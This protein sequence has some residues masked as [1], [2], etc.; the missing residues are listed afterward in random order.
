[1]ATINYWHDKP[2]QDYVMRYLISTLIIAA[3]SISSPSAMDAKDELYYLDDEGS[4]TVGL[5]H[6]RMFA[7]NTIFE[8][9]NSQSKM[10]EH[11]LTLISYNVG[12]IERPY[13]LLKNPN[14]AAQANDEIEKEKNRIEG[15][16]K[17]IIGVI[18]RKP[19]AIVALQQWPSVDDR[20][21]DKALQDFN[22]NSK[23][24]D[25]LHKETRL[26]GR[27]DKKGDEFRNVFIY[28]RRVYGFIRHLNDLSI[29][30]LEYTGA[31]E[32]S[33]NYSPAFLRGEERI[34]T[35]QFYLNSFGPHQP[36]TIINVHLKWQ[37][38]I[39]DIF[40]WLVHYFRSYSKVVVLGSFNVDFKDVKR[41]ERDS[42]IKGIFNTNGTIHDTL[43]ARHKHQIDPQV[44]RQTT[45]AIFY[46][47]SHNNSPSDFPFYLPENQASN[48]IKVA[49]EDIPL[50]EMRSE[51]ILNHLIISRGIKTHYKTVADCIKRGII[52]RDPTV[53][54]QDLIE[55][56]LTPFDEQEAKFL[57]KLSQDLAHELID[58]VRDPLLKEKIEDLWKSNKISIDELV[59]LMSY[60]PTQRALEIEKLLSTKNED[61]NWPRPVVEQ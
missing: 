52:R 56:A 45:D 28:N 37:S 9:P 44:D 36:F 34:M 14:Y 41:E 8:F 55:I 23:R 12:A 18:K 53:I 27:R 30:S 16:I 3:L 21:L 2:N 31:G 54:R 38:N 43:S 19:T 48:L 29:N 17:K 60:K 35:S 40:N 42:R 26:A 61:V 7:V 24:K 25:D 33:S 5:N 11:K 57:G 59:Q 1:M 39:K 20:I 10:V 51:V 49:Y 58:T 50:D 47:L 4:Y 15:C 46:K 32:E 6:H 22:R 13:H